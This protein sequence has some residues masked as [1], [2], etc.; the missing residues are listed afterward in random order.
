MS[1]SQGGLRARCL[2]DV[3]GFAEQVAERPTLEEG[4]TGQSEHGL[5][6]KTGAT[7]ELCE[8][9]QQMGDDGGDDLQAQ[10]PH[11]LKNGQL[12]ERTANALRG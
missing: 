1:D 9:D 10:S 5:C 8:P 2:V 12:A 7:L 11:R 3:S 6:G 4:E